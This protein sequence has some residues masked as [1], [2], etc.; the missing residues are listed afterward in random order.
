[1]GLATL[2]IFNL[3]LDTN[4]FS[5]IL[6]TLLHTYYNIL[7]LHRTTFDSSKDESP[8]FL[9]KFFSELPDIQI[10]AKLESLS[11][12]SSRSSSKSRPKSRSRSRSKSSERILVEK[13]Q[14]YSNEECSGEVFKI[15]F[16]LSLSLNLLVSR[17]LCWRI[18]ETS[19]GFC[20]RNCKH[21]KSRIR[22]E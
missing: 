11:R 1:M 2:S 7:I 18:S 4:L 6:P 12:G 16:S 13:D 3:E 9:L 14:S 5:R 17:H 15:N 21:I 10:T 19:L 20:W 22:N 8:F